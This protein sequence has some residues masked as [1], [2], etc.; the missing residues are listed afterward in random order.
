MLLD[1]GAL[2]RR[3]PSDIRGLRLDQVQWREQLSGGREK[4]QDKLFPDL[5]HRLDHELRPDGVPTPTRVSILGQVSHLF[6]QIEKT[7]V[8]VEPG[9]KS[10]R[11][12]R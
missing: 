4:H 3:Q 1:G 10:L 9:Y 8:I 11:Y 12:P 7:F 6:C 2:R 5:A